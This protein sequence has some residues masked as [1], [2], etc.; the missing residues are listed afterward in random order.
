MD[1]EPVEFELDDFEE[2]P[3][4]ALDQRDHLKIAVRHMSLFG[5]CHIG[6]LWLMY[7]AFN[8]SLVKI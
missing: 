7:G 8:S 6:L 1:A 2:M 4:K 3:V 5:F